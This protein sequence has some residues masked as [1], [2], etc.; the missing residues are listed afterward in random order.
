M[1]KN[2]SHYFE[3]YCKIWFTLVQFQYVKATSYLKNIYITQE[4]FVMP[5]LHVSV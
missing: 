5:R 2:V 3:K 4:S 1:Y